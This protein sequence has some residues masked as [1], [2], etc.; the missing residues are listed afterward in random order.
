[1]PE[2]LIYNAIDVAYQVYTWEYTRWGEAVTLIDIDE[3]RFGCIYHEGEGKEETSGTQ[4]DI[5]FNSRFRGVLYSKETLEVL[6]EIEKANKEALI[7]RMMG[8]L[9][10]ADIAD[11]IEHDNIRVNLGEV[12]VREGD[13]VLIE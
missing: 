1:M 2:R 10:E 8:R 7:R 3:Q 12:H 4:G 13:L 5:Y 9:P 6:D 11:V